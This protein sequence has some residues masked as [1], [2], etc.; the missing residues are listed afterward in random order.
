VAVSCAAED[1][2][3]TNLVFFGSCAPLPML[4][5][6]PGWPLSGKSFALRIALPT[7]GSTDV[8]K[9]WPVTLKKRLENRVFAKIGRET[10]EN[11]H[12]IKR[13]VDTK[14]MCD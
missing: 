8:V 6:L 11:S 10:R 7:R 4:A 12:K 14:K 9:I 5:T 13:F 2:L 3:A 1:G